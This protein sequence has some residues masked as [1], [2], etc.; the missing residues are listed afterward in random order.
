LTAGFSDLLLRVAVHLAERGVPASVAP[1]LMAGL[2]TDLLAEARPVA[3]DDRLGLEAWVRELEL[4]R[5][6]DAVAAL[7]GN[8]PLRPAPSPGQRR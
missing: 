1:A 4:E 2:M 6:D 8:G 3:P 7:A 5:L